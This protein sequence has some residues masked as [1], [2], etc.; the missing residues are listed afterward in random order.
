MINNTHDAPSYH[1]LAC[2]QAQFEHFNGV[3]R[4]IRSAPRNGWNMKP[5]SRERNLAQKIAH[6]ACCPT[7]ACTGAI[8]CRL[9][10]SGVQPR[11]SLAAGRQAAPAPASGRPTAASRNARTPPAV[12]TLLRAL[13]PVTRD[14][15]GKGRSA[16]PPSNVRRNSLT[17]EERG[18]FRGGRIRAEGGG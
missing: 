6:G 14:L 2:A 16:S 8:R 5:S 13:P 7:N 11:G 9:A 18:V 17:T 10:F 1:M 3:S 12:S 15:L 4:P